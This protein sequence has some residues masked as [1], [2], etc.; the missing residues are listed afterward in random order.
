MWPCRTDLSKNKM[1][2]KQTTE[3]P[4]EEAF[5]LVR[6][7]G[8]LTK[9]KLSVSR[10]SRESLSEVATHNHFVLDRGGKVFNQYSAGHQATRR[11]AP[12]T[13]HLGLLGL[14]QLVDSLL[15]LQQVCHNKGRPRRQ[16]VARRR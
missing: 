7:Y 12:R 4:L 14:A 10:F 15:W 6:M 8:R 13:E 16:I 9:K 3:I 5:E 2:G 1:F 11:Q